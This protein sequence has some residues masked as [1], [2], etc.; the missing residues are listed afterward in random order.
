MGTFGFGECWGCYEHKD[1]FLR[2]NNKRSTECV[3]DEGINKKGNLFVFVSEIL[4]VNPGNTL[5]GDLT[6]DY[7]ESG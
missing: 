3:I 6:I 4:T 5:V 7:G 2:G 1:V